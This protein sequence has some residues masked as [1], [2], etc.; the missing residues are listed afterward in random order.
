MIH[1]I[2]KVT[3]LSSNALKSYIH[4]NIDSKILI[5]CLYNFHNPL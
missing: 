3:T 2:V 1:P 4:C 5:I